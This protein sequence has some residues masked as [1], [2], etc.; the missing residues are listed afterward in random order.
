MKLTA[1]QIQVMQ[2]ICEGLVNKE[3]ADRLGISKHT[4]EAHIALA[5]ARLGADRRTQAVAIF[6]R[7]KFGK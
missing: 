4:V 5:M 1:R 2:L 3:I 7:S 6:V